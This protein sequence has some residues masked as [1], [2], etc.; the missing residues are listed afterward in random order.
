MVVTHTKDGFADAVARIKSSATAASKLKKELRDVIAG[1]NAKKSISLVATGPALVKLT[2]DAPVPNIEALQGVLQGISALNLSLA[3]D[4][5]VNF[6]LVINSK[7]KN[8]ADEMAKLAGVGIAGVKVLLKKKA[9]TDPKI[10]PALKIVETMRV[11]S[12]GNNF[13][14]TGEVTAEMLGKILKDLPPR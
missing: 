4:K 5:N 3:L 9:E 12:A 13:V 14:L 8:S 11:T 7:D 6:E 1:G 10:V 2:D